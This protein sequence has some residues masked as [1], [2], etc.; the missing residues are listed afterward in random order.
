MESRHNP[1]LDAISPE[2]AEAVP[3]LRGLRLEQIAIPLGGLSNSNYRLELPGGSLVLRVPRPNPGSFRIDRE[4]EVK[5]ASFAGM[6][7]IGASL[8]YAN[9]QGV[10]LTRYIEGARPMSIEAYRSNPR[11]VQRTADV[12]ARLHRSGHR[13]KRRFNPFQIIDDYRA[14]GQR[15][16]HDVP[17]LPSKL[18]AALEE[19][20]ARVTASSVPLVPS[21]CDL[22]PENCLDTGSRMFL[23]DR[24][25]ARVNDPA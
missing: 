11:S 2:V 14:E 1:E 10:M 13:L 19:A 12:V 18:E 24:E 7:G 3:A 20:R 25:Y 23:I 22:V 8:L 17:V 4:E 5:A 21:H 15:F 16:C 6:A 9:P